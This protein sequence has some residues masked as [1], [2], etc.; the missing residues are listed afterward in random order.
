[1]YLVGSLGIS[2]SAAMAAARSPL[3]LKLASGGLMMYIASLA[4]IIGTGKN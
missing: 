4:A 3:M 2:A 1:M